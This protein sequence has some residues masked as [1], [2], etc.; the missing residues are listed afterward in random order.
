MKVHLIKGY[1]Q[2]TYL[3]EYPNKL[4]LID[5]GCYCD[6]FLIEEYIEKKL[7]RNISE[8]KLILISHIH[9][10]HAGSAKYFQKKYNIPLLGHKLLNSWYQGPSGFINYI[11]DTLLTWYVAKKKK[12]SLKNILH[13]P[14]FK[15]NYEAENEMTI[16]GFSDWLVLFT[17]GHTNSDLTFINKKHKTLYI[18]D[19]IIKTRTKFIT[20][21]P[22]TL[23]K[24]YKESLEKYKEYTDFKFMLAHGEITKLQNSDIEK[25]QNNSP[26]QALSNR[27]VLFEILKN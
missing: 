14:Y 13:N 1:I 10:D 2:S 26:L 15:L 20:P 7:K 16:P 9:N 17:P 6:R 21:H 22:I 18:A 12:K 8:L 19:N 3:I 24:K 4:L 25:L 23:P 27:K 5:S 11:V